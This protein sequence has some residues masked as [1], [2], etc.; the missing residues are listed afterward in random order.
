MNKIS[1]GRTDRTEKLK[2]LRTY[3]RPYNESRYVYMQKGPYRFMI[4]AYLTDEEYLIF[5]L[6]FRK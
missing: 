2:W 4:Y 5:K 1:I 6:M 3:L